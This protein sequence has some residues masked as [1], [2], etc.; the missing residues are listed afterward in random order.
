MN[1]FGTEKFPMTLN[2]VRRNSFSKSMRMKFSVHTGR[3]PALSCDCVTEVSAIASL[4]S[5]GIN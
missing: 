2:A 4:G 5:A 1:A 3:T